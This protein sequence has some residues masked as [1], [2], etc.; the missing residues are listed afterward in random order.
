MARPDRSSG[1][2]LIELMVTI[3]LL[4]ILMAL[5]VPSMGAWIRNNKIRTVADSLQNGLRQAQT[6]ALR[7]SRQVVFSLT[8]ST[9]P[10]TSLA[11]ADNGRNWSINVI[12]LLTDDTD[13]FVASG[14]LGSVGSDVQITGPAAVCFNSMG[15]LVANSGTGV[16]GSTSCD[17]A[18]I[19]PTYNVTLPG[20]DRPLRVLVALGGQVRICDPNRSLSSGQPDG[21]P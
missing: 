1:F 20:A 16:S 2:G 9:A 21:C 4:S 14:V 6:E 17:A 18:S 10:Q 7:R 15:R 19:P 13:V 8:N 3:T 12:K 5:A 11:A